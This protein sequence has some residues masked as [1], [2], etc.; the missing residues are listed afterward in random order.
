[1]APIV[2]FDRLVCRN[3]ITGTLCFR[4]HARKIIYD[5]SRMSL[6]RRDEILL[7]TQ[8]DLKG[9]TFKPATAARS[10]LRWFH[11][12]REPEDAMVE[13]PRLIF[14]PQRHRNQNVIDTTNRHSI[15]LQ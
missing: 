15:P 8:M 13:R 1:M 9:S 12:F 6:A 2:A 7:D 3:F 4:H 10:K 11:F 14:P 5:K